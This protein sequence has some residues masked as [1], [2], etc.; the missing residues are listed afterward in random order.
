MAINDRYAVPNKLVS[1]DFGT[2]SRVFK[3]DNTEELYIQVSLDPELPRW[4]KLGDMFEKAFADF[5][6]Q[7]EFVEDCLKLF[8]KKEAGTFIYLHKYIKHS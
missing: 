6:H 1:A 3:E 2:I 4:E 8:L 7:D 5:L